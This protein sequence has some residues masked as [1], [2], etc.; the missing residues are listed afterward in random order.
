M[1]LSPKFYNTLL[2]LPSRRVLFVRHPRHRPHLSRQ[3]LLDRLRV[4]LV[5]SH[6][7]ALD[8]VLPRVLLLVVQALDVVL[9]K[10]KARRRSLSRLVHALRGR[11]NGRGRRRSPSSSPSFVRIVSP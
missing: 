6:A 4:L 1:Y 10:L 9:S 7:L 3:L 8:L 5:P 11:G 2:L